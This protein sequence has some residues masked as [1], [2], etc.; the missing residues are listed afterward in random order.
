MPGLTRQPTPRPT[1]H[2]TRH[3]T[4]R[5]SDSSSPNAIAA[6]L[7]GRVKVLVGPA[8]ELLVGVLLAHD[9]GDAET[10]GRRDDLLLVLEAGRFDDPADLLGGRPRTLEPDFGQD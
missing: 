2:P 5:P 10:D 4:P 1:R 8:I 6:A 3:P 9:G 7:L